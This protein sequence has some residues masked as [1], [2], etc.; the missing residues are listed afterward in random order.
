[1]RQVIASI[2][3]RLVD[4]GYPVY[5][6]DVPG[7]PTY[8]YV[9]LWTGAGRPSRELLTDDV[10]LADRLGVTGAALT[11]MAVLAV[12]EKARTVLDRFR[13]ESDRWAVDPLRLFDSQD[14]QQDPDVRLPDT[15]RP[16]YFG[17]DLYR[18]TGS[19]KPSAPT[20][21]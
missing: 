16:V 14:V 20:A 6:V 15:N 19:P 18:L 2:E 1:M 12:M 17:V 8:P 3:A 4:A 5:F 7:V 11:P 13:P 10:W 9:L 21:P